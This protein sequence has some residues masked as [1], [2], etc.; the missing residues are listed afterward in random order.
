MSIITPAISLYVKYVKLSIYIRQR[1][2]GTERERRERKERGKRGE[3]EKNP[4]FYRNLCAFAKEM[5][6]QLLNYLLFHS[7]Q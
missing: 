3:E 5:K 4:L 1:Q 2:R 6:V 7:C